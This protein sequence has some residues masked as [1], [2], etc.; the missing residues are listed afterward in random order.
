MIT[1]LIFK[2]HMSVLP[3]L[4]SQQQQLCETKGCPTLHASR[5]TTH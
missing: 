5:H 1:K 4:V 2:V 3:W